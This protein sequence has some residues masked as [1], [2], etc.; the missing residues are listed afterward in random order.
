MNIYT[1]SREEIIEKYLQSEKEKDNLKREIDRVKKE[2]EALE[3][4]LRKYK[5]PILLLLLILI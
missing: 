3:K 4:E 5:I 2:K 1:L